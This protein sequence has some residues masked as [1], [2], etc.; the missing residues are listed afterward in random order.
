VRERETK[1]EKLAAHRPAAKRH[2]G[3]GSDVDVAILDDTRRNLR[4]GGHVESHTS[5]F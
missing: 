1:Q 3:T 4:I 5:F 2:F